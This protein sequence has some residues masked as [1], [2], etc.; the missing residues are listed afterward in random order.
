MINQDRIIK[1]FCDIVQIDSPSGE[2]ESMAIDVVS[3]LEAF[4]FSVTRDAYGNV[5]ASDGRENPILLSAHLDTV[6]PGRGITP[7]VKGDQIVSDG[8]TILGGDCKAGIVAVFEALESMK[9]DG[10]EMRPTELVFTRE[11]E[12]GLVG[13]RNLDMSMLKSKEAIIFD[14]E[15]PVNQITSSSPTYIGFDI[16]IKG[17]AA[18]AGAEPEKGLSAI[19]IAADIINQ[20]PQGRLDNNTTFN[21]GNIAGGS[22]RNTVPENT[23]ITGEFRSTNLEKLDDLRSRIDDVINIVQKK[24]PEAVFESHLHT[25]FETYTLEP[26]DPAT[27]TAKTALERIGLSPIMKP[28]GGGTDGNVFRNRGIS[29]VVVG[30]AVHGM[31]TVREYVNIPDL[32]DTA[33]FCESLLQVKDH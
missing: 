29:S 27:K 12:L 17:R 3:R 10:I 30:M 11:E 8:T 26:N 2:E 6:E 4:G 32:V 18:H 15:G 16:D 21:I 20:L 5:I 14:G 19:A 7:I 25:S 23:L 13:A 31:H 1:T 28:S 24:Y 9:E 33:H 22:T